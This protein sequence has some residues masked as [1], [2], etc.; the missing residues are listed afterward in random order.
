MLNTIEGA[1]AFANQAHDGQVD[2]QGVPYILHPLRVG[3]SLH[4]FGPE[5]VIAGLLHD[6]VEDTPVTLDDLHILGASDAVIAAVNAVTKTESERTVEAYMRSIARATQ[7]PIGGWVKAADVADN[8][9]RLDGITDDMTRKRL[10]R[11]YE[12]AYDA[13]NEAGFSVEQFL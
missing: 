2:K 7:H 1:V 13:L 10:W 6:V 11:K 5:Y 9:G 4:A 8:M 3:A 12:H